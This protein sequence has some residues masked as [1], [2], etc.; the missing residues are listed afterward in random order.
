MVSSS[1]YIAVVSL[2]SNNNPLARD[3]S[4]IEMDLTVSTPKFFVG[5]ANSDKR[6][7]VLPSMVLNCAET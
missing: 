3:V 2:L 1:T 7:N 6:L 4:V 5:I